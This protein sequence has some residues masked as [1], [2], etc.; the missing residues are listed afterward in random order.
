[1]KLREVHHLAALVLFVL[2]AMSLGSGCSPTRPDGDGGDEFSDA[3]LEAGA[4][5]DSIP[6]EDLAELDSENLDDVRLEDPAQGLADNAP[7]ASTIDESPI[8]E[9]SPS[10]DSSS[11]FAAAPV[12]SASTDS[13][14]FGGGATSDYTVQRGD[15]LMKIAFETYGSVYAWR[16][17]YEGNRDRISDFNQL[18]A[19]TV[20]KIEQ[21]SSPVSIDKNG[22][23]YMIKTGDTLGTISDDVYGTPKK[24]RKLY[25]NNRQL[26]KD[27]NKIYAGFYLYY[28]MDANDESEKQ[29]HQSA[30]PLAEQQPVQERVVDPTTSAPASAPAPAAGAGATRAAQTA[31]ETEPMD[32][33]M[34]DGAARTPA[35][36]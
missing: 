1:M 16:K 8:P 12:P 36:Q 27:P 6:E 19:G 24:W 20:L 21:P 32:M 28:S 31:P 3:D 22:T 29:G 10:T 35:E 26:I 13:G 5:T 23:A 18:S 15:T 17:I 25:E 7:P 33:D 2:V 30:K 9:E 4:D 14:S 11:G 34:S